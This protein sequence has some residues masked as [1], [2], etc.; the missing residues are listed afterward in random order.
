MAT[1]PSDTGRSRCVLCWVQALMASPI[2]RRGKVYSYSFA[3][4]I[5]I[6]MLIGRAQL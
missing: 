6:E 3:C 1:F 2:C 5:H 4:T